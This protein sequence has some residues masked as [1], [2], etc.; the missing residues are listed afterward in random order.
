MGTESLIR[1]RGHDYFFTPA[2]DRHLPGFEQS[3]RA[4]GDGQ[5]WPLRKF[6]PVPLIRLTSGEES[7]HY[8]TGSRQMRRIH[9]GSFDHPDQIADAIQAE[10]PP[11]V[12]FGRGLCWC[13][14][15]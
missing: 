4:S 8:T 1:V 11:G 5:L 2:L 12:Y 14:V 6:R 13:F 10:A 9:T 15:R 7:A 3:S